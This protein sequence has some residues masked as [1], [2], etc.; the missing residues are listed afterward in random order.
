MNEGSAKQLQVEE[1]VPQA[2]TTFLLNLANIRTQSSPGIWPKMLQAMMS[3]W[4]TQMPF[5]QEFSIVG[6]SKNHLSRALSVMEEEVRAGGKQLLLAGP[7]AE[8]GAET[9]PLH[10]KRLNVTLGH[11]P[12]AFPGCSS[13]P[14]FAA[15]PQGATRAARR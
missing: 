6:H 10:P 15:C 8:K 4:L 14:R 13:Q 3:Y 2:P 5:F 11:E 7:R 9:A 12:A 1:K